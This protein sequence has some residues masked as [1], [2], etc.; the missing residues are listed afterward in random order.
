M[1]EA[2]ACVK[3]LRA[4]KVL[5]GCGVSVFLD[6]EGSDTSGDQNA[7]DGSSGTDGTLDHTLALAVHI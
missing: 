5:R 2:G 3:H 4:S 6:K 1:V 7:H